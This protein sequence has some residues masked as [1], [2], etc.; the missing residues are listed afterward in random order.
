MA[1]AVDVSFGRL[2]SCSNLPGSRTC[3][4]RNSVLIVASKEYSFDWVG[5]SASLGTC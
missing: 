1:E 4:A 3:L 5:G 2:K